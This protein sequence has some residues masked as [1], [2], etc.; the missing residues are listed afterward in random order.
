MQHQGRDDS[1]RNTRYEVF[2]LEVAEDGQLARRARWRAAT[3]NRRHVPRDAEPF[4]V[5]YRSVSGH[6]VRILLSA[7][8]ARLHSAAYLLIRGRHCRRAVVASLAVEILPRCRALSTNRPLP[9][10]QVLSSRSA[11]STNYAT[12]NDAS[13]RCAERHHTDVRSDYEA[14]AI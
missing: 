14:H 3:L 4:T 2:V 12:R 6:R 1:A 13:R 5:R 9:R 8:N 7:S 11:G 10:L